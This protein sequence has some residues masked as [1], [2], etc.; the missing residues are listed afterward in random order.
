MQTLRKDDDWVIESNGV[1]VVIGMLMNATDSHTLA[2]VIGGHQ[3]MFAHQ[4]LNA[5]DE[6]FAL[7]AMSRSKNQIWSYE[8]STTKTFPAFLRT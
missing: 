3:I 8:S 6:P 1:L 7:G 5:V 2:L 4:D